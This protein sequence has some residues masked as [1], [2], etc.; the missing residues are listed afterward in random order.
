MLSAAS[1]L[2][3][4]TPALGHTYFP[5]STQTPANPSSTFQTTQMTEAASPPPAA[6]VSAAE[7]ELPTTQENNSITEASQNSHST[8]SN[9]I[10]SSALFAQSFNLYLRYGSEYMDENPLVGEPGSFKLSKARSGESALPISSSNNNN[11][12]T[13]R[14]PSP[15]RSSP[16]ASGMKK[17]PGLEVKTDVPPESGSGRKGSGSGKSPTTPGAGKKKKER[18]KTKAVGAEEEE[19][20]TPRGDG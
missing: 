17:T 4:F 16:P 8:P 10:H 19:G 5:P 7:N 3:T 6:K 2:P 11:D 12:K 14:Q 20:E 1:S 9:D 15:L 18:R 13:P